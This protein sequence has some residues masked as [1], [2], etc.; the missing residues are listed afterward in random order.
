MSIETKENDIWILH[1]VNLTDTTILNIFTRK[2]WYRWWKIYSKDKYFT[3]LTWKVEV[4]T[5][6]KSEDRK[7]TYESWDCI[8]IPAWIPNIFYFPENTEMLEWFPKD[9]ETEKYERYRKFK[10]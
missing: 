10:K 1:K 3:I 7:N 5:F 6:E 4:T 9:V 2:W 8:K